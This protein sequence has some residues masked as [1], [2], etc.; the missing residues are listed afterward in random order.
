MRATTA[1]LTLACALAATVVEARSP[2]HV[3]GPN[4]KLPEVPRPRRGD[5]AN[6]RK[7]V[8]QSQ[9]ARRGVSDFIVPQNA[10]TTKFAVDGTA[11]PEVDF[12][13]GESYAGLLPISDKA[14]ETSELY[15]WYFPSSNPEATDEIT[16][17]L[18]G[19][20]GC[21]SLEGFLQENGPVLW[22][23]GTYKPIQNPWTWVNLTNMVWVEQ[24][25]GTGF[26]QGDPTASSEEEVAEQ[27]LGFFKNFV[28]TFALHGRKVYITGESYAGL[29]VP[30]IADAMLNTEDKEY[31][32]LNSIM[33][34]DPSVSYDVLLQ[35]IP[36]VPFVDTWAGLFNLNDTFM[37]DIH[38]RADKCGYTDFLEKNLV[39]PPTG[40]LPTPPNVDNNDPSCD[41]WDAIYSA[42]SLT[43]PCF[44]MY[45][46][47]TTCPVLWDVLGFPG[48]FDY[49]P[50]GG[51]IYFNRTDV[52]KAINAPVQEWAECSNGVL[53]RDT[54]APSGLSVLPGVIERAERT[55]IAHGALDFI[56]LVN[57]TL[58]TIQNMTWN[59]AQGFQE[60]PAQPFYV[61]YHSDTSKSTLAASG[62]MGTTH[63]ERGLTWVEVALSGHMIP[64]YQPS[65]AFRQLEF[66]L[67][68]IESLSVES[69]F[70][71]ET[72][73]YGN[74]DGAAKN[75][76][77][78]AARRRAG[79]E[80]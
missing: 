44:D 35:Q 18:N 47:A 78:K 15:F 17:W 5:T 65:A 80:W 30:Y 74:A 42:V 34:Y 9:N 52:Q 1:A 3:L 41:V 45:Q 46:V 72:G 29:Y 75:A 43:N 31:Y 38:E 7:A 27:F 54:S 71:T 58:L 22:Q 37:E 51:S 24:P 14:N 33:I 20:P 12:D 70:T 67:G 64:Q 48:S 66:L 26:S 63:T 40:P 13:V 6:F 11:I 68:R 8:D 79:L 2:A 23:Y 57:G 76:T 21:S 60:R 50:E 53:D 19:G 59:G 56:L 62:V 49:L 61:P 73:A 4:R 69:G 16:I 55:V 39:F 25:V 36:A 32:N 28:D 10:N 77:N